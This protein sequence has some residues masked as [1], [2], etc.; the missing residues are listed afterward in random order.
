MCCLTMVHLLYL[1]GVVHLV[2]NHKYSVSFYG[3]RNFEKVRVL[4]RLLREFGTVKIDIH[5]LDYFPH[6][7]EERTIVKKVTEEDT[8]SGSSSY[9]AP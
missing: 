7:L 8:S 6:D 4:M 3:M 9:S 2:G 5:I 1:V